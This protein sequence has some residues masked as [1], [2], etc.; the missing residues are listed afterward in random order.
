MS[1]KQYKKISKFQQIVK[2]IESVI[3]IND[4]KKVYT[5]KKVMKPE[6]GKEII[7]TGNC[8]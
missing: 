4:K 7:A 8:L 5:F 1:K 6:K 2:R 3:V